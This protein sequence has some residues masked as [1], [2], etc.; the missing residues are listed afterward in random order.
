MI[1]PMYRK[2]E[3]KR[4]LEGF[5]LMELI[6]VV[7]II[8]ILASTMVPQYYRSRERSYDKQ[9]ESILTSIRAA[10]RMYRVETG[11]YYCPGTT[12]VGTINTNLNLDLPND[13]NW[14]SYSIS[15]TDGFTSS[16]Q[17]DGAGYNRTWTIT[18]ITE[19]ATCS[20]NCP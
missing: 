18:V 9:A 6:V 14:G 3:I 12:N 4:Y 13:G 5:T 16:T 7:I 10:E 11:S 20:G 1:N 8:G 19:N 17:R 15:N 2:L